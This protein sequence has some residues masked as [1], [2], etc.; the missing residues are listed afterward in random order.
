MLS[1]NRKQLFPR[2]G[3]HCKTGDIGNIFELEGNTT[4][5]RAC[6]TSSG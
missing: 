6:D 1:G 3:H 4:A 2:T 5:L